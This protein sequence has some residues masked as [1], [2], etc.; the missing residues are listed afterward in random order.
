M[1]S[2]SVMD[3]YLLVQL[4]FLWSDSHTLSFSQLRSQWVWTLANSGTLMR[5]DQLAC[6]YIKSQQ[7][8]FAQLN[9]NALSSTLVRS[10][11]LPPALINCNAVSLISMRLHGS[12]TL[13]RPHQLLCASSTLTPSHQLSCALIINPDAVSSTLMQSQQLTHLHVFSGDP[14]YCNSFNSPPARFTINSNAL[15]SNLMCFQWVWILVHSRQLLWLS[16]CT[17]HR[18]PG[19]WS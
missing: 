10:H 7:I 2:I 6:T 13:T 16:K 17:S 18:L 14:G 11:Q 9:S 4:A 5:C 19:M 1:C 15:S 3:A 8:P 12:S